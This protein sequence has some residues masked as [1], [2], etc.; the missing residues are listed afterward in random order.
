MAAAVSV[1]EAPRTH[2]YTRR[3]IC[4]YTYIYLT[5]DVTPIQL[6]YMGRRGKILK[7]IST[8]RVEKSHHITTVALTYTYIIAYNVNCAGEYIKGVTICVTICGKRVLK[9]FGTFFGQKFEK[10][11]KLNATSLLERN[12]NIRSYLLTRFKH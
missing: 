3:D 4:Y 10:N 9:N 8:R 12:N 5:S 7:S 11:W 6:L 1:A 2:V